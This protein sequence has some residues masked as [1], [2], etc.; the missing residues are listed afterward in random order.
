MLRAGSFKTILAIFEVCSDSWGWF[1]IS[2]NHD[3]FN[4]YDVR[5]EFIATEWAWASGI[6]TFTQTEPWPF[7]VYQNIPGGSQTRQRKCS[8]FRQFEFLYSCIIFSFEILFER[9]NWVHVAN[10]VSIIA[11]M[12]VKQQEHLEKPLTL[13]SLATSWCITFH[14]SIYIFS[15]YILPNLPMVPTMTTTTQ[16][17]SQFP[18]SLSVEG[19]KTAFIFQAYNQI[20][21]ST[22]HS[23]RSTK[24][25]KTLCKFQLPLW[26]P[27][28]SDLNNFHFPFLRNKGDKCRK[29]WVLS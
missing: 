16:F 26:I 20:T 22:V 10:Y 19:L 5:L 12:Q 1:L 6:F 15:L 28:K 8:N 25:V 23:Y 9:C 21:Y 7:A 27:K 3:A 18:L 11:T 2:K 29:N 4:I 13:I 17:L 14:I 24:I